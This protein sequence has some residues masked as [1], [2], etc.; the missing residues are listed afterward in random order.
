MSSGSNVFL[1]RLL[2]SPQFKPGAGRVS[3]Y[4]QQIQQAR[5]IILLRVQLPAYTKGQQG[6]A[7]GNG[8]PSC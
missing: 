5:C 6:E 4:D 7:P 1:G 2:I 8:S 3:V